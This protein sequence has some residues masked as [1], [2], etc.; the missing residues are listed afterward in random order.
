MAAGLFLAALCL[1]A[2]VNAADFEIGPQ[3]SGSAAGGA[4]K[5]PAP[6]PATG[7]GS[8]LGQESEP[9]YPSEMPVELDVGD[10]P[11][12]FMLDK[13]AVRTDFRFYEGGGILGKAYLGLFPRFFIGGAADVRNFVGSGPLSINQ[14]DAQ[15][16]ARFAILLEDQAMPALSIGWDGPSYDLEEAKGL[17]LALTKRIPTRLCFVQFDGELNSDKIQ[18]FEPYRDLRAAAA[19]TACIHNFGVFTDL[20]EV[21]AP[22]GPRW[23]A[24][25]EAYFSPITLG[26]EFRDL[27]SERPD[28]PVS[29]LLRVNWIGRF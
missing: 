2:G 20:D 4:A 17:Y 16:L 28:T 9:A 14:N 19:A 26:L 13:Y 29:R 8:E 25:L 3:D 15:L 18:G 5:A 11:T 23:C 12:A 7:Q 22:L 24:G 10:V 21:M 27:A 6:S 1:D